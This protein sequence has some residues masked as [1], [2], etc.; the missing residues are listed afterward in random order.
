METKILLEE[1]A[2]KAN[3]TGLLDYKSEYFIFLPFKSE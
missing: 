2:G 3:F 1:E